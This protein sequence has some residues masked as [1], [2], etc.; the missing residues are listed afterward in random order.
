MILFGVF[1]LLVSIFYLLLAFKVVSYRKLQNS[2]I[3]FYETS[4]PKLSVIVCYR[5][6]QASLKACV[7]SLISQDY[8][9]E[10]LEI[11]FINDHS[12]DNGQQILEALHSIDN[13]SLK[14]LRG[15]KH[16]QNL[17]YEK[18]SGEFLVFTDADCVAGSNL[19]LKTLVIHQEQYS[20]D[21]ILGP[22]HCSSSKTRLQ[23]FQD[24]DMKSI[25]ALS[26]YA[27]NV[28]KL[29]MG[30]A[31]NMLVRRK[32]FEDHVA[33]RHE[34]VSSGDDTFLLSSVLNTDPDS[35]K[36]VS[37]EQAI[38]LTEPETQLNSLVTQR[39]RWASKSKHYSK[40]FRVFLWAIGLFE[41]FLLACIILTPLRWQLGFPAV[42]L[43]VS[44]C[45]ALHWT[46]KVEWKSLLPFALMHNLFYV[47]I[48]LSSLIWKRPK[49]KG[50]RI[51]V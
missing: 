25:M 18:S 34:E 13:Y 29:P 23:S 46:A 1:A 20:T 47:G 41:L 14:D 39:I 43:L 3:N 42:I 16:A 5:N 7:Q 51:D 30:S 44:K 50:R 9:K 38:I 28:C 32:T 4:W 8:P 22:V 40:R 10:R 36:F 15:K 48:G 45:L 27:V 26:D 49:W 12:S 21:I 17:G 37:S 6:E 19:W 35:V 11:I 33:M 31:A 24:L 2:E